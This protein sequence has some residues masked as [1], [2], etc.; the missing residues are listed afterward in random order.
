MAK[1]LLDLKNQIAGDLRRTN[2]TPEI[3]AAIP[4]A[5]RDHD[6]ERFWFNQ[7][8]PQAYALTV[9]ANG[10]IPSDTGGVARGDCYQLSPQQGYQ[11]F[12]MIDKVRAQLTSPSGVWYTVK[13]TD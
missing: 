11:E 13:Q 3:A 8:Y 4:T 5:I 1:T 6:S 7:T 9:S 12:I 10:G 2:L